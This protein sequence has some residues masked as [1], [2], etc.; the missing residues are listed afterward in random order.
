MTASDFIKESSNDVRATSHDATTSAELLESFFSSMN[1]N[2]TEEKAKNLFQFFKF[3][4]KIELHAHLNGCIRESTLFELARDRNVTLSSLL[5]EFKFDLLGPQQQSYQ[6]EQRQRRSL[7]ECFQIFKEISKC[8]TDLDAIYRIT[9]EALEDFA[10]QNVA[11]LELRST[12]KSLKRKISSGSSASSMCTKKE[13]IE[14]ILKAM[15]EFS[16]KEKERYDREVKNCK[17]QK[18]MDYPSVSLSSFVRLPLIPR[19]IISIDR[20]GS[21]DDAKE[22]TSLAI[23]FAKAKNPFVVGLDLSGDPMKNDF[24]CLKEQFQR[25]REFG[26]KTAIHCGEI[27]C[28]DNLEGCE[29]DLMRFAFRE[30]HSIVSFKPDRLGHALLLPQTVIKELDEMEEKIPIECCPTSNVMTLELCSKSKGNLVEGLRIHPNLASWLSTGYPFSISTDDPGL[31]HTNST[32]ELILVLE[33][34]DSNPVDLVQLVLRSVD[35]TFES[36]CFKEILKHSMAEQ[37]ETIVKMMS[38]LKN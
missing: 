7:T 24:D 26:L 3:L 19:L 18:A 13:Y 23:D 10:E 11:Y 21:I 20:S 8:V 28:C 36:E 38:A 22:H 29:D 15:E 12:P 37:I 9:L 25:V 14:T 6:L 5:S 27:P 17:E 30:A 31:F 33:A 32:R 2:P 1:A 16:T 35:H 4:P 34:F